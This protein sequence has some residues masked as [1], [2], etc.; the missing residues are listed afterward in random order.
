MN[1]VQTKSWEEAREELARVAPA[2]VCG[3]FDRT[4]AV[5]HKVSAIKLLQAFGIGV[6]VDEPPRGSQTRSER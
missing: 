5:G 4:L 2:E 3:R 6:Y 1:K